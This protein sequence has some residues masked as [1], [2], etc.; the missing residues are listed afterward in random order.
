MDCGRNLRKHGLTSF[1]LTS[2]FSF[3]GT[4]QLMTVSMVLLWVINI[5]SDLGNRGNFCR[6]ECLGACGAGFCDSSSRSNSVH[7]VVGRNLRPGFNACSET[8]LC[9]VTVSV[10]SV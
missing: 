6:A 3:T 1:S 2:D 10:I 9:T 4:I 5:T 7:M 8:F